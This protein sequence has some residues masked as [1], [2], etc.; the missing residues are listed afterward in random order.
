[1]YA[2]L[3]RVIKQELAILC[4]EYQ[5]RIQFRER[6]GR[7]NLLKR[8]NRARVTLAFGQTSVGTLQ[9]GAALRLPSRLQ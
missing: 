4:T 5:M 9:P 1:M 2:L 8:G 6:L 7:R 3:N